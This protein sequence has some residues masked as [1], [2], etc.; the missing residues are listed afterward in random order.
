MK[1]NGAFAIYLFILLLVIVLGLY[2]LSE[3]MA[4]YR[5]R[6]LIENRPLGQNVISHAAPIAKAWEA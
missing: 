6:T 2:V 1:K 3:G 5:N 4:A